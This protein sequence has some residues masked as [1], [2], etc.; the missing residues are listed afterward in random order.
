MER[1]VNLRREII[2]QCIVHIF[3]NNYNSA[4]L[5]AKFNQFKNFTIF[6]NILQSPLARHR[7][8]ITPQTQTQTYRLQRNSW[9]K[10]CPRWVFW[11]DALKQLQNQQKEID[12]AWIQWR[13]LQALLP[14]ITIRRKRRLIAIAA[15]KRKSVWTMA[16]LKMAR[17]VIRYSCLFTQNPRNFLNC[18]FL[19]DRCELNVKVWLTALRLIY[20]L[21]WNLDLDGYILDATPTKFHVDPL[22]KI[23]GFFERSKFL[24]VHFPYN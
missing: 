2:Y 3:K 16:I 4:R 8:K 14:N 10:N 24:F 21:P 1:E 5:T 15:V 11:F 6:S 23:D 19:L 20:C 17:H 18:Y 12:L 22:D 7:F 9:R 13:F